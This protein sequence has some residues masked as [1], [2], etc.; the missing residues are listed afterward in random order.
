VDD[1]TLGLLTV[2]A[3]QLRDVRTQFADLSKQPGPR[4]THGDKGDQGDT[5]SKG[6][7]GDQGDTGPK[8][9]KG[10]QGDTGS[11]GD[12]G[13]HGDTGPK[14]DK[15]DQG[16]TGPAPEHE[17]R[18][19][20]L[21]FRQ[22][23]DEWGKFVDLA[24]KADTTKLP[25]AVYVATTPGPAGPSG[26]AGADAAGKTLVYTGDK[27]TEVLSYSDAAKTTLVERRVLNYT[28][29]TLTVIQFYDGAGSL[30]KTRTL[31]YALGVVSGYTDT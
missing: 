10:D 17:W 14:G 23:D 16:D 4:G 3:K 28:G 24:G 26:D 21:R 9:D 18:G 11:K 19:T 5:G 12:K 29:N 22:P 31:T 1:N 13:D 27:L 2:V 20:K 6:D 7:K 15:G 25:R 30:T 8:G